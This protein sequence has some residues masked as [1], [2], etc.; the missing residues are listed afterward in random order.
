MKQDPLPEWFPWV[1]SISVLSILGGLFWLVFAMPS[2]GTPA[3]L[4]IVP[5]TPWGGWAYVG[6]WII[7]WLLVW[8]FSTFA[9]VNGRSGVGVW[10]NGI[11]CLVGISMMIVRFQTDGDENSGWGILGLIGM[12]F[13]GVLLFSCMSPLKLVS[14]PNYYCPPNPPSQII[15]GD[16]NQQVHVSQSANGNNIHQYVFNVYGG[17][18]PKMVTC[19]HCGSQRPDMLNQCP[20]C[21]SRKTT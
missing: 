11:L 16:N 5:K 15:Q 1:F 9:Q 18:T 20:G 3:S 2:A 14:V 17:N 12:L 19:S 13:H 10:F 4:P 7:G 8:M 6:T 21:G